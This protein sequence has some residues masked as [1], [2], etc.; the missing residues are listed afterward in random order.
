VGTPAPCT[1]DPAS[2]RSSSV[3]DERITADVLA[4]SWNG[5]A[6]AGLAIPV[7]A[8]AYATITHCQPVPF[9]W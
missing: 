8:L 1:H 6:V 2:R 3:Q 4:G 7:L 9:A 5:R